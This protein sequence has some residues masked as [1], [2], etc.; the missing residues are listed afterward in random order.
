M[1][2]ERSRDYSTAAFQLHAQTGGHE[3]YAKRLHEQ[4]IREAA[5]YKQPSE[6]GIGAGAAD[7][8]AAADARYQ[9]LWA[10]HAAELADLLAVTE[11]IEWLERLNLGDHIKAMRRVYLTDPW[12]ELDGEEIR[13]RVHAAEIAIPASVRSIYYWLSDCRAIFAWRRGLILSDGQTRALRRLHL[14]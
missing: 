7:P 6:T 4:L 12:A 1:R 3:V 2:K 10:E 5:E 11:T 9:R 14:L 8:M 13:E